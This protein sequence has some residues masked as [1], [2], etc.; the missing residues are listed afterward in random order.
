MGGGAV[1]KRLGKERID[2]LHTGLQTDTQINKHT[3]HTTAVAQTH[4]Y[5]QSSRCDPRIIINAVS[6]FDSVVS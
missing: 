2:C 5:E 3:V 6:Y 1:E 4:C